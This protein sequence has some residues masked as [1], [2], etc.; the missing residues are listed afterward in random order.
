MSAIGERIKEIRKQNGLNQTKFATEL[1]ISQNHVSNIENGNENPSAT[2]LKLLCMKFNISEEWLKDGVGARLQDFD[3]VSDDGVMS[4]YSV[5]R[6]MLEQMIKF[7]SGEELKNTVEA[8]A[9][10]V[11]LLAEDGLSGENRVAY[12]AAVCESISMIERQEFATHCLGNFGKLGKD[13][14]QAQ[15][16]YKTESEKRLTEI[17]QKIREMNNIYLKQLQADTEL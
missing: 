15:L 12:L 2:L 4:K 10:T 11:S 6:G 8:F 13:S 16:R 17:N 5:M 14:Y 1:G 7:R 9:H 3:V